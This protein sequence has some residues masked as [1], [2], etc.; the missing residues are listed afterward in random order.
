MLPGVRVHVAR[1]CIA[2]VARHSV[3]PSGAPLSQPRSLFRS[4]SLS[5]IT[6]R[7]RLYHAMPRWQCVHHA[8]GLTTVNWGTCSADQLVVTLW[9]ILS[10]L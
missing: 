5:A 2:S 9:L 10:A 8:V 3:Q 6:V 4:A 7:V 1:R